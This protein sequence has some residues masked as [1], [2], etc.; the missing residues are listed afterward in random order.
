[1]VRME[2]RAPGSSGLLGSLRG[3]A[4][5]LIGSAHDRLELLAVELHEEKYRL[6]QIF[7]W[8]S[9][10]VF[11]AM[12]AMVFVSMAVLVLLW[13]K[14][15]IAVVCSLAGGYLIGLGAAVLGF[16]RYLKRQPKP[17]AATLSELRDDRECIRAES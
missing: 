10:I 1:M 2:T 4:D 9:G 13:D 11:L 6:I 14:A 17:F 16:R 3:F 7:I 8:I 15:R 12:L 5:G